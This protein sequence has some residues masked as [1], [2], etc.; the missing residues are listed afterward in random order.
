MGAKMGGD[1][2]DVM[3]EINI[4]PMVDIILVLLIIFMVTASVINK[5]AI[6]V[7]LGVDAQR[8]ARLVAD[9]LT[10]PR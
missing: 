3:A 8:N 4:T 9:H 1:D 6:E 10:V 7:E 2:D 5:E